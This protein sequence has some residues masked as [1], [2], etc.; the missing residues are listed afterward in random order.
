[1]TSM[2]L[3]GD[4]YLPGR[5]AALLSLVRGRAFWASASSCPR[6]R[7]RRHPASQRPVALPE[8]VDGTLFVLRELPQPELPT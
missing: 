1:M 8:E 5:A 4:P 7:S 6:R 3:F 2:K